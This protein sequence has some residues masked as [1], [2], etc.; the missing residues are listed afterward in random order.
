MKT[1]TKRTLHL[2]DLENLCGCATCTSAMTA[3]IHRVYMQKVPTSPYDQYVIATSHHNALATTTWPGGRRVVR[4]GKD[5]ADSVLFEQAMDTDLTSRFSNI[6]LASGDRFFVPA[7]KALK[8]QGHHV[9]VVV[10]NG[11]PS[12]AL[13]SEADHFVPLGVNMR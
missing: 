3:D 13:R 8:E 2:I 4:S 11:W 9:T 5:G 10:A 12:Y 6:V 7:A 1:P